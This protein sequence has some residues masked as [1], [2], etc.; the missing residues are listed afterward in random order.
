MN[1]RI[2]R[3][4]QAGRDIVATALYIA[5]DGPDTARRF[6]AAVESTIA[7]VA[8]MPGMGAPRR[9]GHPRLEG[10]RTIAVQGFA[11]H[12]VFYRPTEAVLTGKGRGPASPT[13]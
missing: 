12:L 2:V 4:P 5:E 7:A 6:L 9:Y 1:L 3:R 11:R 13:G 8:A 10:L